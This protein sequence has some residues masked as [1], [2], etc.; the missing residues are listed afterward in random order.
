MSKLWG[1]IKS[2]QIIL[3]LPMTT[4]DFP[5]NVQLLYYFMSSNFNIEL[6]PSK[7]LSFGYLSM[8]GGSYESATQFSD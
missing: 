4:A 7:S 3:L 1:V 2:L 5:A 8:Y 6:V